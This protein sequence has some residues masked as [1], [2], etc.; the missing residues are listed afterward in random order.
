MIISNHLG[1]VRLTD[2]HEELTRKKH[3]QYS[4][5]GLAGGIT[6]NSYGHEVEVRVKAI[7]DTL[8]YD[9]LFKVSASTLRV[10]GSKLL[11]SGRD[12]VL[13]RKGI[14]IGKRNESLDRLFVDFILKQFRLE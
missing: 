8:I 7:V 5:V 9:E 1:Q 2:Y 13:D 10:I 4:K 3:Y 12:V 14:K 11:D 6:T